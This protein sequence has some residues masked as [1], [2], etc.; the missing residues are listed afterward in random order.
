MRYTD[1]ERW[2]RKQKQAK[3]VQTI[4]KTFGQR[5]ASHIDLL[6][7][8]LLAAACIHHP[9]V[10]PPLRSI[11]GVIDYAQNLLVDPRLHGSATCIAQHA[12][13][14]PPSRPTC[15]ISCCRESR[16][17]LR[18][19]PPGGTRTAPNGSAK[20]HCSSNTRR[21]ELGL[22]GPTFF[23]GAASFSKKKEREIAGK[24]STSE[25]QPKSF[26][27]ETLENTLFHLLVPRCFQGLTEHAHAPQNTVKRTC[28]SYAES[29][30]P[31]KSSQRQILCDVSTWRPKTKHTRNIGGVACQ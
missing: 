25:T 3:R 20:D 13:V 5:S 12:S 7:M 1:R 18:G 9:A 23:F 30:R 28:V 21:R 6:H 22:E 8:V 27:I 26:Y 2:K 11:C 29:K 14:P 15:I 31:I 17:W 10:P 24:R 4:L 16:T 19:S